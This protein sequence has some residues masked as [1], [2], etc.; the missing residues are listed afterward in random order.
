MNIGKVKRETVTKAN[1][2]ETSTDIHMGQ[3]IKNKRF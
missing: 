2:E 1:S 3:D